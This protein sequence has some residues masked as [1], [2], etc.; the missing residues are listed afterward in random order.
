MSKVENGSKVKVHYSGKL[1]DG[2]VFDT[3]IGKEPLEF[4]VGNKQVIQGFETGIIGLGVGEKATVRIDPDDAYG[5]YHDDYVYEVSK[6]QIPD[7]INLEIGNR[8]HA[9]HD[10]E[11]GALELVIIEVNEDSVKLDANHPL[12]G[13]TLIFDIELI[14][15]M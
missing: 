4:T 11:Q 10:K 15:V 13:R 12:A 3:S 6:K 2:T 1:D 8:I 5:P 9:R 14:E 7:N